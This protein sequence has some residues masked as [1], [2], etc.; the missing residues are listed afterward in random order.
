MEKHDSVDETIFWDLVESADWKSDYNYQ[1]IK[2]SLI[3]QLTP[4]AIDQFQSFYQK[5]KNKL[6]RVV[7]KYC[8]EN[9]KSAG[10]SDDSFSDLIAHIVGLGRTEYNQ[11]LS[12]P[13]KVVEKGRK[14]DFK[15]S[16]SYAIPYKDDLKYF[17]K[18]Y[19]SEK[20]RECLLEDSLAEAIRLPERKKEAMSVLHDIDLVNG[21]NQVADGN[22]E[23]LRVEGSGE[24]SEYSSVEIH[25]LYLAWKKLSK[26][27]SLYYGVPNLILD[28]NK[29]KEFIY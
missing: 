12:Q 18:S 15:E 6:A 27:L 10:L 17:P 28:Y 8:E 1:R 11:A 7:D 26:I 4:N 29:Y 23:Y 3:R 25:E 19:Y 24:N 22:V 9:D 14:G 20:A 21:L 2:M 16:F 13:E 5:V